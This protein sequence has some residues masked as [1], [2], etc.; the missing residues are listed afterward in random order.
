MAWIYLA[1]AAAFEVAFALGMKWSD[2]FTRLW[3]TLFTMVT[4]VG[5]IGFLTLALKTL[6]VSVAY[7]IWT[8]VGTLGTVA[9]GFALLGESLTAAKVVSAVAIMAGVAGLKVS[10]G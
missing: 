9:L 1:T 4:V 3:P 5:G 7:P 8:A 6:P 2:G 10:A